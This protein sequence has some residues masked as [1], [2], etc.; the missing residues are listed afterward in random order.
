MFEIQN[1]IERIARDGYRI[2]WA[3]MIGRGWTLNFGNL[4]SLIVFN[5]VIIGISLVSG[6]VPL[7]GTLASVV[8]GQIAIACYALGIHRLVKTGS[9]ELSDFFKGFDYFAQLAIVALIQLVIIMVPIGLIAGGAFFSVGFMDADIGVVSGLL[10]GGVSLALMALVIYI[11]VGWVFA[12]HLVVFHDY[13]AW[14]AMKASRAIVAK[15]WWSIFAIVFFGGWLS[16]L[17]VLACG[18][19]IILTYAI[20]QIALYY[21]FDQIVGIELD[22]EV[23]EEGRIIDHLID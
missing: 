7:V 13:Q 2:D 4:G 3:D 17:G 9:V 16:G 18:I 10:L 12:P 1:K 14:D 22:G 11:Y 8:I 20:M 21:A 23:D 5:L 6:M 15:N 19:G